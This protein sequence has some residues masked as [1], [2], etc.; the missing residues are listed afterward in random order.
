MRPLV[1][2]VVPIYNV[3]KYLDRCIKS[4]TQQTLKDIEI[5]LVDDES[6]DKCPQLCDEY[7]SLDSRIKVIHKKNGG[8]G[9]A[10]NSGMQV[11]TGEYITFV[12]SDDFVALETY[13]KLYTIAKSKDLDICYFRFCRYYETG[14]IKPMNDWNKE[15]YFLTKVDVQR[16]FLEMV[17]PKPEE[18]IDIKYSMSV[19]KAIF[20][21]GILKANKLQFVSERE[22]A[23]EDLIFHLDLVPYINKIGYLPMPYYYY[24]VNSSSITTSYSGEK[25]QRLLK[26]ATIVQQR[27]SLLYPDDIYIE[28]Y[29]SQLLRIY[30]VILK[31]E[32]INPNNNLI[33]KLHRIK[34]VCNN[35]I[36]EKMY[37]KQIYKKYSI[38]N[39]AFIL[40]MKYGI[41]LFFILSYNFKSLHR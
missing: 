23:S 6:P 9:L 39:R 8:L 20:K 37:S 25:Y 30:K 32:S 29:C 21:L 12:D 4:L 26:L 36:L 31:F 34:D 11:A 3:E 15:E 1:S 13:E 40:C 18:K 14:T 35:P 5:I 41:G 2:I 10:R 16:F 17:G 19:C 33:Q 27:L 7:A 28:H 22:V 38:K 24:Y